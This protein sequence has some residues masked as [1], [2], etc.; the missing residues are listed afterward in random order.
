MKQFIINFNFEG[1]NYAA[2]VTEIGGLDDVQYAISQQDEKLA[3]KFKTII[4]RKA[5][6]E[7]NYQYSL[8]PVPNVD[9]FMES[10]TKGLKDYLR[11]NR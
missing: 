9:E 7:Q 3:E 5:K 4:V 8:P 11:K 2:D 6:N 1:V 10:L